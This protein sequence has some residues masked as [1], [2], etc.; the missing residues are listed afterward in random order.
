MDK[1]NAIQDD[2]YSKINKAQINYKKSPKSRITKSYVQTRLESL[3]SWWSTFVQTHQKIINDTFELAEELY[4]DYKS[5]LKETLEDLSPQTSS[6]NSGT[7]RVVSKVDRSCVKLPKIAIPIFTGKYTEWTTFHDLFVS[8]IH[9][10]TSLDN[11]QKLHYLK[12]HLSGEADQLLRH[13][14]ITSDNYLTCWEQLTS[15]YSNKRYIA[16]CILERFMSL[17]SIHFESS[18]ALKE[19]LD[20]TNETLNGLQNLGVKTENWDILVIYILSH[21][22]DSESRKQ[23]EDK[24]SD[25]TKDLPTLTQFKEFLEHRFRALEFLDHKSGAEV[26]GQILLEGL[27]KGPVGSPV[28]QNTR[29]GWILSGKVQAKNSTSNDDHIINMH[30]QVSEDEIL[31]KFWEIESEP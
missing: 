29:L 5:E 12:S 1:L 17:K 28:A 13:I 15:R 16:N 27:I 23:W 31:R 11:V 6:S 25:V 4:I 2:I 8:L 19:L 20:T 22:L 9:K 3:E 24:I 26:Y 10:N 18:G 21:K 30:L 14:P 7:D